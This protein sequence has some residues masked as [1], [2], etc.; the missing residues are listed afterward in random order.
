MLNMTNIPH[1]RKHLYFRK[2]SDSPRDI[3]V[4]SAGLL[5]VSCRGNNQMVLTTLLHERVISQCVDNTPYN[6]PHHTA[7]YTPPRGT[8]GTLEPLLG[9]T[10]GVRGTS[11]GLA[12]GSLAFIIPELL[13]WT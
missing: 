6:T 3:M 5:S 11:V 10:A 7:Q 8:H 2:R 4:R 12:V 1:E 9:Y 13:A